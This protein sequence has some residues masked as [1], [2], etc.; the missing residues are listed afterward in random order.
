MDNSI[1]DI[2]HSLSI[3]AETLGEPAE[4]EASWYAM[5]VFMNKVALCRDLFN[6]FNNALKDPDQM[7]NTFPEDMMGDV[8]EYYAPF[9][10]ER[11]VNSQGKK[12]VVERPLIPSLFFMRSNKRQALWLERE[13]CGKARLYRQLVDFDPQPIAIPTPLLGESTHP[14]AQVPPFAVCD[15]WAEHPG[16]A[17]M[18]VEGVQIFDGVETLQDIEL[19]PLTEGQSSLLQNSIRDIPGQDL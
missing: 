12:I 7:K 10:K 16:Y 1:K 11:H 15:V 8:M 3:Q 13:L 2:N 18:L 5:R 19:E 9:V 4:T 17:M 14:G 6:L